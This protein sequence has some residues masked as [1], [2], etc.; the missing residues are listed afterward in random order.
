M[1]S[2]ERPNQIT[3][4]ILS[5][6]LRNPQAADNLEGIARWRLLNEIV[7][8]RV[9]E[10]RNALNWLVENGFLTETAFVGIEPVYRL[11]GEKAQAAEQLLATPDPPTGK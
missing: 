11:N 3:R 6:F 10:T 7:H 1:A 4:D 9:D 8:R 2:G 5:Y